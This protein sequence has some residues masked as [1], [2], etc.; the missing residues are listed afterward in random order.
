MTNR[1]IFLE[2]LVGVALSSSTS[3]A[4]SGPADASKLGFTPLRSFNDFYFG[5]IPDLPTLKAQVFATPFSTAESLP[6]NVDLRPSMPPVY[7]QGEIGSCTSNALA[8]CIQFLR[9]KSGQAPDFVPSRL[10]I[11]YNGRVMEN[12]IGSDAGLSIRDGISVVENN[13]VCSESDWPYDAKKADDKGAFAKQ[14]NR[15]VVKP[16]KKIY[17]GAFTHRTIVAVPIP[18]R[19]DEL[20]AC[21]A[22]GFPFSFGFTVYSSFFDPNMRPRTNIPVPTPQEL[23]QSGHAVVAVGYDDTNRTFICRNSWNTK[24]AQGEVQDKGHFYMPYAY[25]TDSDLAADFWTI[26]SVNA[27]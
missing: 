12:T 24:N 3:L 8:A 2:R 22:A 10:F 18:Q 7:D 6:G 11:Y 23:P 5:W 4:H 27:L 9:K 13:G 14:G 15:A 19:L 16:P 25:T 1:R 21:L 26:R 17:D 20:R